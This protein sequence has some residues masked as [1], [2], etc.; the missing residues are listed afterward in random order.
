M[1]MEI[2]CRQ[3]ELLKRAIKHAKTLRIDAE[4]AV[5]TI[6]TLPPQFPQQ[7]LIEY[8]RHLQGTDYIDI[9]IKNNSEKYVTLAHEMIHL[10]QILLDG[11]I[12]ENEAYLRE[13]S[14]D[15]EPG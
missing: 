3:K 7:G 9:Y 6:K 10:K 15:N 12:D 14:L 11:V 13:K 5:L 2:Y 4:D 1:M 8:P